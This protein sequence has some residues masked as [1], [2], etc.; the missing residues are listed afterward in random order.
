MVFYIEK[1]MRQ[2]QINTE[3]SDA[4]K[5][6]ESSLESKNRAIEELMAS[7]AANKKMIDSL[8]E[9]VKSIKD[10]NAE[11]KLY[12]DKNLKYFEKIIDNMITVNVFTRNI[13]WLAGLLVALTV[14]WKALEALL[15]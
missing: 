14:I 2:E 8:S 12:H 5:R 10:S 15:Q 7:N 4:L 1:W 3:H 6:I 9:C 11:L 13:K